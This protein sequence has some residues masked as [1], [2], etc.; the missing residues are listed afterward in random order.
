[1]NVNYCVVFLFFIF[2]VHL[3]AYEPTQLQ[4]PS[5]NSLP[6]SQDTSNARGTFLRKCKVTASCIG[7]V[8]VPAMSILPFSLLFKCIIQDAIFLRLRKIVTEASQRQK[9]LGMAEFF[10][11]QIGICIGSFLTNKWF[12]HQKK[13]AAQLI[14]LTIVECTAVAYLVKQYKAAMRFISCT[15][16]MSQKNRIATKS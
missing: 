7:C 1:M 16:F 5:M 13:P 2:N 4:L 10:M 11:Y 6:P 15:E 9:I 14:G 8:V 3:S 12:D